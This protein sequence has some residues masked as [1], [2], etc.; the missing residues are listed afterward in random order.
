MNAMSKKTVAAEKRADQYKSILTSLGKAEDGEEKSALD[1]LKLQIQAV[2]EETEANR[3]LIQELQEERAA[4][5]LLNQNDVAAIGVLK[6]EIEEKEKTVRVLRVELEESQQQQYQDKEVS[7]IKMRQLEEDMITLRVEKQSTESG[8]ATLTNQYEALQETLQNREAE[9]KDNTGE[10]YTRMRQVEDEASDMRKE[11]R[12][13]DDELAALAHRHEQDKNHIAELQSH[14]TQLEEDLAVQSEKKR[15]TSDE[16]A[17]LVH[18]YESLKSKGEGRDTKDLQSRIG[19]LEAQTEIAEQELQTTAHKERQQE[20]VISELRLSVSTL[21]G[22]AA[23][24]ATEKTKLRFIIEEKEVEIREAA[25]DTRAR[26]EELEKEFDDARIDLQLTRED[27]EEKQK[28]V[29]ELQ[30]KMDEIVEENTTTASR[31]EILSEEVIQ[32]RNENEGYSIAAAALREEKNQ[33][34]EEFGSTINDLKEEIYEL[35]DAK[36]SL[37]EKL[38]D[39]QDT[40]PEASIMMQEMTTV[41]NELRTVKRELQ[42]SQNEL[43]EVKGGLQSSQDELHTV[44]RKLQSSQ[45]ELHNTKG[46][47]QKELRRMTGDNSDSKLLLTEKEAA[48]KAKEEELN[49]LITDSTKLQ[50]ALENSQ[51][52][53]QASEER[54]AELEEKINESVVKGET[55]LQAAAAGSRK[56]EA[57]CTELVL[58]VD[59]LQALLGTERREHSNSK[60]A[61]QREGNSLQDDF[62]RVSDLAEEAREKAALQMIQVEKGREAEQRLKIVE[63]ELESLKESYVKLKEMNKMKTQELRVADDLCNQLKAAGAQ[64]SHALYGKEQE[65]EKRAG[66]VDK[67]SDYKGELESALRITANKLEIEKN[68]SK[69][70][71]EELKKLT[72]KLNVLQSNSPSR[73]P[74]A[75]RRPSP[76]SISASPVSESSVQRS[77]LLDPTTPPRLGR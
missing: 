63:N 61:L 2:V 6:A 18:Q 71:N 37:S 47:L 65:M 57:R 32:L 36:K 41:K 49:N 3:M 1:E 53:L 34:A 20:E 15:A 14:V 30:A 13:A 72:Q 50:E 75:Y 21:Q 42:S 51:A 62:N 9:D 24:S 64:Q 11:K 5:E 52:L 59:Q 74:R 28:E 19:E 22:E 68:K 12:A 46:E 17:T 73:S 16:M 26:I 66:D 48:L 7:S 33:I 40:A 29:D 67:L 77:L 56:L 4:D 55:A 39:A 35:H 10:L 45:D 76:S 58:E 60:E 31:I 44:K 38:S 23:T 25:A 43:H 70:V 54:E 27:L 69:G 8:L